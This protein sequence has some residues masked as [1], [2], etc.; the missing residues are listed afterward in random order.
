MGVKARLDRIERRAGAGADVRLVWIGEGKTKQEAWRERYGN[1][2]MP[3]PGSPST[4]MFL[5]WMLD[6]V[7]TVTKAGT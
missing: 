4:V 1:T 2:P 5:S 7:E 3:A 6:D